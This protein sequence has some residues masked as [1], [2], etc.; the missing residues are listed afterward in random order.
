MRF[1]SVIYRYESRNHIDFPMSPSLSLYLNN[2]SNHRFASRINPFFHIDKEFV[3]YGKRRPVKRSGG[4]VFIFVCS[5][6]RRQPHLAKVKAVQ[7]GFGIS[8]PRCHPLTTDTGGQDF[9]F[10]KMKISRFGMFL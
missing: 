8:H 4:L 3:E 2:Y 10:V 9:F 1:V 5:N 6:S 7:I